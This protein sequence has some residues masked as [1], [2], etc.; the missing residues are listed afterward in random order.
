MFIGRSLV[1]FALLTVMIP[2]APQSDSPA[3]L[4][5]FEAGG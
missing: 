2:S 4:W 1:S 3:I 5:Q